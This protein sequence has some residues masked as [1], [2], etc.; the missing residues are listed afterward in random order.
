VVRHGRAHC[1]E[2][3]V[4]AAAILEHHGYPPILMDIESVDLLDHVLF[5]YRR[6]GRYGVVARSRDPGLHG[7]RPVYRT[8]ASLVRSYMAPYIDK[9]GRV[10]GYG[11]FD[12]RRLRR[13]DW[14]AS[15]R[16][17]R[18]IEKALND[19]HHVRLRT[20]DAFYRRW[21]ARYDAFK[22]LHTRKSDKPTYFPGR[23]DWLWP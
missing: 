11:V 1:L 12:L 21:R 5:V 3:A 10:K 20:P 22:R 4:A 16:H 2:A 19:N 7:R 9:T 15:K 23:R 17:V 14:R 6:N 8:L 13:V 18:A